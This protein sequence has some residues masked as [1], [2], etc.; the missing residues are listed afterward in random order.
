MNQPRNPQPGAENEDTIWEAAIR[1]H[2]AAFAYPATPDI[3]AQVARALDGNPGRR[4]VHLR[5]VW[6]FL[7]IILAILV[8][9]LLAPTTRAA[10][11]DFLQIG[12][13]R[14]QLVQPTATPVPTANISKPTAAPATA[15]PRFLRSWLDLTGEASLKE[16]REQ[17]SI[18]LRLPTYPADLGEPDHV[19]VQK[20][21]GSGSFVLL[22]W[23]EPGQSEQPRLTL[24]QMEPNA[25][26]TKGEPLK[27][28]ETAVHGNQA[29]W[30][31]GPYGLIYK[32]EGTQFVRLIEGPV[33]IWTEVVAGQEI[34]YRLESA[35]SMAEAVRVAESLAHVEE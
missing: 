16:A 30:T 22:I 3:A 12:A 1:Q 35:L 19:F 13:V 28:S 4:N 11:V 24:M 18:P 32:S 9:L 21:G 31:L 8:G 27:I 15:T 14:I 29:L 34:T 7:L 10:I 6:A 25:F 20:V 33:L 2:A 26:V 5:P 17:L 23:L